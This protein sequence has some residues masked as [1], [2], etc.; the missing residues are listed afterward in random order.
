MPKVGK[1]SFAYSKKGKA[2]ARRYKKQQ[3]KKNKHLPGGKRKSEGHNPGLPGS[4]VW[5]TP[6]VQNGARGGF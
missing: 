2:A 5:A 1:K 4:A 6:Y 3:A